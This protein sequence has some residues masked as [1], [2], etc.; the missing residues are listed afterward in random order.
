MTLHRPGLFAAA[1]LAL[2]VL[3]IPHA[4]AACSDKKI[5]AMANEGR[6]VKSIAKSCNMPAAKVRGVVD[7][8]NEPSRP[9][10]LAPSQ[11]PPPAKAKPK[12]SPEPEAIKGLPSGAGL[13]SCD[14]KGSVPYGNKAPELRCQSGVSIATPCPGYCSPHGIAPWRRICS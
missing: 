14:C 8:G 1:V 5:A 10:A 9:Q 13:A 7:E 12:P 6:S 4:D 11:A 2:L 3:P